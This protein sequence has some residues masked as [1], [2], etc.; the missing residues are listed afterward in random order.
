MLG[1]FGEW[2]TSLSPEGEGGGAARQQTAKK[3]IIVLK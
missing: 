3:N 1:N 2:E